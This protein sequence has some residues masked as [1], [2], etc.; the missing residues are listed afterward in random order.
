MDSRWS[1]L[2][3]VRNNVAKAGFD[4]ILIPD[5]YEEL[6]TRKLLVMEEVVP[7]TPLHNALDDQAAAMAKQ[8]GV[9]KQVFLDQVSRSLDLLAPMAW[10]GMPDNHSLLASCHRTGKSSRRS[11]SSSPCQRGQNGGGNFGRRL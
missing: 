11:R 9:S 6:C 4:N 10:V 2:P 3:Q 1:V 7:A 8:K 5:V